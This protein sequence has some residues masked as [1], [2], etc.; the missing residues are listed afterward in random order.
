VSDLNAGLKRTTSIFL[1]LS[2]LYPL[3]WFTMFLLAP[4]IGRGAAH[5]HLLTEFFAF[6]GVG[7]LLLGMGILCSNLF[8]G[9]F[10]ENV[11]R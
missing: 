3:S 5:G 7:G 10:R 9:L 4:S 8:L 11:G 2:S 1:G 6:S